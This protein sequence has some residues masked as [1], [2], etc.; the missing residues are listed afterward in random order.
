VLFNELREYSSKLVRK[1][2]LISFSKA[3]LVSERRIMEVSEYRFRK[4]KNSPLIFSSV[5]GFGINELLNSFWKNLEEI[6]DE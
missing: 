6:N 2:I 1:K 4:N 5:S 3:D